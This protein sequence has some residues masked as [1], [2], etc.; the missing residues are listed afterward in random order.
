MVADLSNLEEYRE[1]CLKSQENRQGLDSSLNLFEA[2][3]QRI[4]VDKR[5]ADRQIERAV[6]GA[7]AFLTIAIKQRAGNGQGIVVVGGCW[8]SDSFQRKKQSVLFSMLKKV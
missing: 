5:M 8:M 4:S 1:F 3:C 6:V 2:I 7:I